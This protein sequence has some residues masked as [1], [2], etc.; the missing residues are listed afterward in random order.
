MSRTISSA[1]MR[2]LLM[3]D[4]FERLN[5]SPD[6]SATVTDI[7]CEASLSGYDSHGIVRLAMYVSD[8]RQGRTKPAA[9]MKILR[10]SAGSE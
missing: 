10:E 1:A 4:V 6:D 5:V 8:L 9:E 2:Q 3:L 7:L